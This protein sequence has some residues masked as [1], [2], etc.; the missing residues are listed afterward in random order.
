MINSTVEH[1]VD[2]F[3][4]GKAPVEDTIKITPKKVGKDPTAQLKLLLDN[5][6]RQEETPTKW[7]VSVLYPIHKKGDSFICQNYRGISLLNT[8]YKIVSNII[9]NRIQPY[10]KEI[11]REY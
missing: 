2:M 9:L 3:T 11:V 10:S 4:N 1:M 7:Y 6:W 8:S 5:I